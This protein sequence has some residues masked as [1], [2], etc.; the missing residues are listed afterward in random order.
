MRATNFAARRAVAVLIAAL[1]TGCQV[2]EIRSTNEFGVEWR[3]KGEGRTNH[4][5]YFVKPGLEL[6]WSNDVETEVSFRRRD[7][8]DGPGDSDNGL[9]FDVSIPIWR[10]EPERDPRDL[11]IAEL[12]RRLAA[13]EARVAAPS[14]ALVAERAH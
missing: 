12:E 7:D 2:N 6:E 14:S 8:N 13:L 11:R 5:R 9:F 10:R 4:E 3:H 1:T